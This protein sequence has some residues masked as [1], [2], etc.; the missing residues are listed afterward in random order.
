[1][2]YT[3]RLE[4]PPWSKGI[5]DL[6]KAHCCKWPR[7]QNVQQA[8]RRGPLQMPGQAK[9]AGPCHSHQMDLVYLAN[10]PPIQ[11]TRRVKKNP[12]PAA[13]LEIQNGMVQTPD[14]GALNASLF[15]SSPDLMQSMPIWCTS[16]GRVHVL[17]TG[18]SFNSPLQT[19]ICLEYVHECWSREQVIAPPAWLCCS[20]Y[21]FF[22]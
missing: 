7:R 1:V 14:K 2:R 10:S 3:F 15:S 11:T 12:L 16:L 21:P 4:R 20:I 18:C 19:Y 6:A 22:Q 9:W 17:W 8:E 5:M 13:E